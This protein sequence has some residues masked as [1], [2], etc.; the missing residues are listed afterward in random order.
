MQGM[1]EFRRMELALLTEQEL[2][3][4]L[5][6][7]HRTIVQWRAEGRGPDYVKLGRG[8][9]YRVSDISN[10]VNVNVRIVERRA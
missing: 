6:V 1:S 4:I 2:A 5:E 9:Y 8:I 7:D 3:D 10:W